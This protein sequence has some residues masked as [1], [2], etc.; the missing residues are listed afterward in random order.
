MKFLLLLIFA[1][2][3]FA[4]PSY[5][6]NTGDVV[7]NEIAWMGT[8][9]S[10]TDEW[11]E[12]TNNT[13]VPVSLVGW[14][15]RATDGK[16]NIALE[17]IIAPSAFF[18]LERT[19]D[20]TVSDT[21]ADQIY[22]G[23]LGNGGEHLELIDERGNAI[24]NVNAWGRVLWEGFGGDNNTKQTMER[25]NP[26]LPGAEA[27]NWGTSINPGGTPRTQ[28][29]IYEPA[30]TQQN[31][32]PSPKDAVLQENSQE[33]SP[34]RQNEEIAATS[35]LMEPPPPTYPSGIFIN[36]LMPYPLGPD[37]LE[38]W[39]ELVNEND[40]IADVSYWQIK[41][42]LGAVNIYILNAT[43]PAKGYLVLSRLTTKITMNNDNDA[44]QLVRPDKELIQTVSYENAPK[45]KSYVRSEG[46]WK[47]SAVPTPGSTNIVP[48]PLKETRTIED[49]KKVSQKHTDSPLIL[50]E[51]S[52]L[53]TDPPL[54]NSETNPISHTAAIG[55]HAPKTQSP[56]L[57]PFIASS[58]ALLSS[59]FIF[60][61]KKRLSRY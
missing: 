58:I 2:F 20:A 12:L 57:V 8:T 10:H 29:S 36:E 9:N 24:D 16:P 53:A 32:A 23:D 40:N 60:L 50:P 43:I 38:E 11:I 15:L 42:T 7:I 55:E 56:W 61:L 22:T 35:T 37:E 13:E 25:R 19:N 6:T 5:A 45:G 30:Q 28:N 51:P 59:L 47:W 34:S 14:I 1:F 52:R 3:S 49:V 39:I 4:T 54:I 31:P 26:K 17:G 48:A 46:A 27:G 41:D 18:L 44:I 21:L 33:P